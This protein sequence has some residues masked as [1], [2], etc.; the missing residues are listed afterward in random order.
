MNKYVLIGLSIVVLLGIGVGAVARYS[1][2]SQANLAQIPAQTPLPFRS[3][4]A[5]MRIESEAKLV[6][7]PA[8]L[9]DV[10]AYM[11][12]RLVTDKTF[13]KSLDPNLD[14]YWNDEIFNDIYYDTP[15]LVM[16]DH[17]S[18][19]RYRTRTNLTNPES[20]KNGR[21]LL[22]VKLNDVDSDVFSRGEIKFDIHHDLKPDDPDDLQPALGLLKTSDRP[23]FKQLMAELSINPYSLKPILTLDQ[24]RRSI[25]ITRNGDAFISVRLDQ[26]SSD[27]LWAGWR[28][29]EIEPEL[30]EIP[31]TAADDAGKAYMQDINSKILKDIL[32]KAFHF[33]GGHFIPL[34]YQLIR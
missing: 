34:L 6:V 19:I 23:Q 16:L 20:T 27:M 22:Q 4:F 30:N 21:E 25:Y 15:D 32:Q 18:G 1:N 33:A 17:Q 29:F 8:I 11:L 7:P 14:S 5:N 26:D 13:L 31:F 2:D 10:W 24:R 9:E 28:H 12:R 3:D